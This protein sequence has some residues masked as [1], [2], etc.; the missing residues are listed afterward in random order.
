[1][2]GASAIVLKA[3]LSVFVYRSAAA[4]ES[5][6]AIIRTDRKRNSYLHRPGGIRLVAMS[7]LV[8][9][10]VAPCSAEVYSPEV[11]AVLQQVREF[12]IHG[13][14]NGAAAAIRDGVARYPQSAQLHFM[15]GNVLMRE[16]SWSPAIP[17]YQKAAQLR[18]FHADTY[19]NLGYAYYHTGRKREA[20]QAWQVASRQSPAAAMIHATLAVG[21][22]EIGSKPEALDE[23]GRAWRL[24]PQS[25]WRVDVVKDLRWDSKMRADADRLM[26]D[27][28][29]VA[30]PGK[31]SRKLTGPRRGNEKPNV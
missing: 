2:G 25:T 20:V 13:D 12:Y 11:S 26:A 23:L 8:I 6:P 16:H 22:F 7:A 17:Q 28:A 5:Y 30:S 18:P 1:M 4:V 19:L 24:D 3:I 9:S 21:L 29:R 14:R 15:L 10:I 27:A 31:D